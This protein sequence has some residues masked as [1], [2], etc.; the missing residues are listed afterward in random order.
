MLVDDHRITLARERE[1]YARHRLQDGCEADLS[2]MKL[3]FAATI[4]LARTELD[5]AL[6]ADDLA[7]DRLKD[8]VAACVRRL[9]D[10]ADVRFR[11]RFRTYVETVVKSESAMLARPR[12]IALPRLDLR[13]IP[14]PNPAASHPKE[15]VDLFLSQLAAELS[16]ALRD[17]V[18]AARRTVIRRVIASVARARAKR[19]LRP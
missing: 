5:R 19:A 7:A 15:F 17:A 11:A 12:R 18:E 9:C 10:T 13:P 14:I 4:A 3:L 16:S 2:A 1:R 6:D 8:I